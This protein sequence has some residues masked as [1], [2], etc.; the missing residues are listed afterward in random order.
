M[1]NVITR[2][3]ALLGD[4]GRFDDSMTPQAVLNAVAALAAMQAQIDGLGGG[5][6]GGL[7]VTDNLDGTLTIDGTTI[8]DNLDGTLTIGA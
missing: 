5:G 4:D 6:G 2:K 8:T 7:T 1:P 3:V